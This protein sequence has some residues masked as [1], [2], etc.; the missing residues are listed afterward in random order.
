MQ[1]GNLIQYKD[2]STSGATVTRLVDGQWYYINVLETNPTTVVGLYT[3]YNDAVNETNRVQLSAGTTNG[4]FALNIG[5]K[6]SAITSSSP[7]EKTTLLFVLIELLT[8]VKS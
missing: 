1:T 4:D 5:A 3:S 2:D 6:A 8:Q 7:T